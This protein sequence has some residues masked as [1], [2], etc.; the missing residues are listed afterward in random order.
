MSKNH[1]KCEDCKT[2][3]EVEKTYCPIDV[4]DSQLGKLR[5]CDIEEVY[6]CEMCYRQRETQT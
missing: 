6:L 2:E 5:L 4:M 1:N 3:F